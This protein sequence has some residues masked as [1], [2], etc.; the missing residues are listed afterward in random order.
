MNQYLVR[1]IPQKKFEKFITDYT[2]SYPLLLI[3]AW[4]LY[5]SPN[6]NKDTTTEVQF[7]EFLQTLRS[8][9]LLIGRQKAAGIIVFSSRFYEKEK[10]TI[11]LLNIPNSNQNMLSSILPEHNPDY[12]QFNKLYSKY[13]RGLSNCLTFANCSSNLTRVG[14]LYHRPPKFYPDFVQLE[15]N[16]HPKQSESFDTLAKLNQS[17]SMLKS[18]QRIQSRSKTKLK[19]YLSNGFGNPMI[20]VNQ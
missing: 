13:I 18:K 3:V 10:A 1:K 16:I 6:H 20:R 19:D 17:I 5:Y 12:H 4:V 15:R 7:D 11:G 8:N 2:S 14:Q 9:G